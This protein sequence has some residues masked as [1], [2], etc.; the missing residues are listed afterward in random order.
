MGDEK[1]TPVAAISLEAQC[2]VLE[3]GRT[4]AFTKMYDADGEETNDVEAAVTAL[5]AHPDG[6]VIVLHL[7]KFPPVTL[8]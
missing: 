3:D 8:H 2:V 4:A 5:A 7:G 1:Y 6:P